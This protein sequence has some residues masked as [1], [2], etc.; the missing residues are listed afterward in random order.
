MPL[1]CLKQCLAH[2]EHSINGTFCYF[3]KQVGAWPLVAGWS[4]DSISKAGAWLLY[5]FQSSAEDPE[6]RA[7]A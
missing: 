7:W 3:K 5:F 4:E 2:G 1:K 6:G